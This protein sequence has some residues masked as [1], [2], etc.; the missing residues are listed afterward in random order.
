[1]EKVSI[2]DPGGWGRNLLYYTKD[3]NCHLKWSFVGIHQS[4][5][6]RLLLGHTFLGIFL[7]PLYLHNF[8]FVQPSF[9]HPQVK[10]YPNNQPPFVQPHIKKTHFLQEQQKFCTTPTLKQVIN[11]PGVAGA[12]LQTPA[13]F[14][15]KLQIPPES[16]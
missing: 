5:T 4:F 15:V 2:P 6:P 14:I 3:G 12:V 16:G 11:R 9:V 10:T 13:S 7:E 1:M 8:T